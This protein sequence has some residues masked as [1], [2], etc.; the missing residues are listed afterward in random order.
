MILWK[1][2]GLASAASGVLGTILLFLNT[3]GLQSIGTIS[4]PHDVMTAVNA[5]NKRRWIWQ[6]IGLVFLLLSFV[7]A[8]GSVL[9]AP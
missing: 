7:L 6:R 9:M 1:V 3:W 4:V 2:L 5:K 8:A